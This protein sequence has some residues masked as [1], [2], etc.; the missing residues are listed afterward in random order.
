MTSP[1]ILALDYSDLNEAREMISKVRPY[2]GMIKIGLELFSSVGSKEALALSKEFSIPVF[3][4]LKLH[5][6]PTTVGNTVISLCE[7]FSQYQYGENF[8]SVH[9]S[10]GMDMC[11]VAKEA[12]EGSGV[13]IVG[14]SLLT[15]IE[16]S[17][18]AAMKFKDRRIGPK[19]VDF[20]FIG[21]AGGLRHFVC[22][23]AQLRV[24]SSS[25]PNSMFITPGIRSTNDAIDDHSNSNVKTAGF[26]IKNGATWLVIGRPITQSADPIKSANYILEQVKRAQV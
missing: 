13:T 15:S 11:G 9:C 26:A 21:Y 19:S 14:V 6:I 23:P 10:G 18:L 20:G 24:F 16:S 7:Q 2:I 3:L 5:D 8:I 1:I 22:P 17:D 12:A 25:L 4:D